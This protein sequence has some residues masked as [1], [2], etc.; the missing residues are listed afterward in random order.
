MRNRGT[1]PKACR[2]P[3]WRRWARKPGNVGPGPTFTVQLDL[4]NLPTN[5]PGSQQALPGETLNLQCVYRDFG[6]TYN[7]TD[8]VSVVFQ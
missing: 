1:F 8:A 4:N 5:A 3:A 7:F 2:R 6:N